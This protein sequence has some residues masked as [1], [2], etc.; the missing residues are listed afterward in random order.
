M[1][2]L[3]FAPL[4]GRVDVSLLGFT[5]G[6]LLQWQKK[7]VA[8]PVYQHL[9]MGLIL[10]EMHAH[11]AISMDALLLCLVSALMFWRVSPY[12][13]AALQVA[14]LLVTPTTDRRAAL[15][16]DVL[17]TALFAQAPMVGAVPWYASALRL[18]SA[19]LH[20][21]HVWTFTALFA[22]FRAQPM[23][24]LGAV[25]VVAWFGSARATVV[26]VLGAIEWVYYISARS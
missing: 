6:W 16:G 7:S 11:L 18:L 15:L 10:H 5:I 25:L 3:E 8:L 13:R 1:F 20:T 21:P 19:W 12:A 24:V 22:A 23:Q 4:I 9:C 2:A 26:S 17:G 14:A